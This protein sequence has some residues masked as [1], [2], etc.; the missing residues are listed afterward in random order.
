[1]LLAFVI[2]GASQTRDEFQEKY[3]VLENSRYLIRPGIV[4]TV[5][6][7]NEGKA[8][9]LTIEPQPSSASDGTNAE[10]MSSATVSEIIDE[11]V[12]VS[13]RGK[14]IRD[15]N[16]EAGCSSVQTSDYEKISINRTIICRS[17]NGGG[18]ASAKI[19]W[20]TVENQ[21]N[22]EVQE[23]RVKIY[24]EPVT[25]QQS[26]LYAL[27]ASKKPGGIVIV[28]RDCV[29]SELKPQMVREYASLETALNSIVKQ[30]PWYKWS[31]EDEVVNLIPADDEPDFL[32]TRIKEFRL[33]GDLNI[34]LA[35]DKLLHL[36]EVEIE[37]EK[38]NLN[39]GLRNCCGLSSP[40]DTK[41]RLKFKLKDITLR[42]ALNEIARKDGRAVWRYYES[43]CGGKISTTL[44]WLVN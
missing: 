21:P 29:V 9:E 8:Q 3:G 26:F 22:S 25:T 28:N 23:R 5:L 34:H 10:L 4:M 27:I 33:D 14:F 36:P 1:M 15:I 37:A 16:F 31:V 43:N 40:K 7:S 17:R 39:E 19:R 38:I 30:D 35:L 12:P 32:K 42:Q 11:I 41:S 24:D 18:E 20:K 13:R 6:Y 2:A 44:D